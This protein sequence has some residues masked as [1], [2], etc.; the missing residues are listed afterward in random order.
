MYKKINTLVLALMPVFVFAGTINTSVSSLP[1]FGN[2]PVFWSATPQSFTLSGNAITSNIIISASTE[3]E[4]S[5][6]AYSGFSDSIQIATSTGN[7]SL[8]RIFVRFAPTSTGTK[9][10]N[11]LISS[12]GSNNITLTLSGTAT[13]TPASGTNAATYYNNI[14]NLSGAALK[15][16]LFNK[17]SGHTVISYS[18]LY[19]NFA[20]SDKTYDN[21]VWD[22]YS[23]SI[24]G[25]FATYSYVYGSGTCGN[26]ANEGDC[27]NREHSFPQS[28]FASAS[29]MQSDMFHLYPTDGK[30]NGMRDNNAFSEVAVPNW[31]SQIGAKR[32]N[33][34]FSG[35]SGVA[36]EP[37]DEYKGDLARSYFYMA[38]RYE[39]LIAGWQNNGNANDVL[40]GNSFPAYDAW[41]I[42]LLVKWHNQDPPST[43]EINRNNSI[44]SAQN[45]RNPFIDSPQYVN[46][47]WGGATALAPSM[48][49]TLLRLKNNTLT[50]ATIA[51]KGGNGQ[52]RL[53][54]ARA[55]APVNALPVNGTEYLANAQFGA[56]SDLGNG[57]F[58]VYNGMGNSATIN[59]LNQNQ[60]YYF[61]VVEYNGV[62]STSTY[63]NNAVLYSNIVA[64]P[65][66]WLAVSA[67]EINENTHEISWQTTNEVNNK[68]FSIERLLNNEWL[69]AARV[70]PKNNTINFYKVKVNYNGADQEVFYRIKQTDADGSYSYSKVVSVKKNNL[71]KAVRISPN[72][73]TNEIKVLNQNQTEAITVNVYNMVGK[74]MQIIY[75]EPNSEKI[76]DNMDGLPAGIYFFTIMQQSGSTQVEHIIKK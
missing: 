63:A 21:K 24:E 37:I 19:T 73:F 9:S 41:Y 49:S 67:S 52:R 65:V 62:L 39:N 7:V 70:E 32:G 50:S 2:C 29:P 75:V 12:V 4:V 45:N 20:N 3:F 54:I 53:V 66:K 8:T 59:N 10:G 61:A 48:G 30:V 51:W 69:S 72:P 5:L 31:T 43:K 55:G 40:A 11:I 16:A 35:F 60:V 15:T 58:V 74:Q 33:S 71:N 76:V 44:Y 17:I 56:G 14:G 27:Y 46:R 22:I 1:S 34:S 57:N 38:T 25:P 26:Y 42:A 64:L 23:T 47:I 28:W 18:A 13:A 36:F 68:Y 6:S